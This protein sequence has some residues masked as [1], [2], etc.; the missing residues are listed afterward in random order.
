M[1]STITATATPTIL[2]WNH[3][4]LLTDPAK[5]KGNKQHKVLLLNTK[6][7]WKTVILSPN[8]VSENQLSANQSQLE[9]QTG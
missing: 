2:P 6:M 3:Q 4:P 7:K 5:G 9:E 8:G 1:M